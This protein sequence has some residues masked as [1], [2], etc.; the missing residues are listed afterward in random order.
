MYPDAFTVSLHNPNK[1][2]AVRAVR[3]TV[4]RLWKMVEIPRSPEFGDREHPNR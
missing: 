2:P 3:G 4:S 1:M